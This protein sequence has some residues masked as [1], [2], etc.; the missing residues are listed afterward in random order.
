MRGDRDL[1]KE[2]VHQHGLAAAD[3]ADEIGTFEPAGACRRV[4]AARPLRLSVIDV[5]WRRDRAPRRQLPLQRIVALSAPEATSCARAVVTVTRRDNGAR[6]RAGAAE[7][8]MDLADHRD[9]LATGQGADE[10]V[11]AQGSA[12]R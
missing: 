8:G 5:G 7:P 3:L 9:A 11:A 4:S 2:Q 12:R 6:L 1:G 10:A